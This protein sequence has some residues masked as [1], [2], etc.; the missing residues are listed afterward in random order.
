MLFGV[1]FLLYFIKLSAGKVGLISIISFSNFKSSSTVLISF[2][3]VISIISDF[4]KNCPKG[5]SESDTDMITYY[6]NVPFLKDHQMTNVLC[7]RVWPMISNVL[8]CGKL[9]K[10]HEVSVQ[11]KINLSVISPAKKTS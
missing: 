7:F 8:F 2:V 4:A 9:I 6:T 1:V 11:N 3:V 10:T 5:E